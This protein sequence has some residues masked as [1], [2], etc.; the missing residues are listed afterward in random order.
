M[1]H[2][3][4]METVFSVPHGKSTWSPDSVEQRHTI[5]LHSSK[6]L[7]HRPSRSMHL[8][9]FVVI[10]IEAI[11]TTTICVSLR[12]FCWACGL[13]GHRAVSEDVV[14]VDFNRGRGGRVIQVDPG[15]FTPLS[16]ML[17]GFFSG[18]L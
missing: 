15:Y 5:T 6:F 7:T 16:P 9:S 3:D 4:R 2:V 13:W 10:C 18:S 11:V 12:T 8:V 14:S 1:A 17:L